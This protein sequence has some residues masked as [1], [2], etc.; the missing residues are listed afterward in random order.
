MDT[1][2]RTDSVVPGDLFYIYKG[3]D[4]M[5]QLASLEVVTE[6]IQENLTVPGEYVTQYSAPTATGQTVT[7]TAISEDARLIIIPGGAYAAMT[8]TLPLAATSVDHQRI[9]VTCTQ[10]IATLTVSGNGATVVNAPT[11]LAANA[12]F[13]FMYDAPFATWYRVG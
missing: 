6:A 8:I 5:R 2:T 12:F 7:M 3:Q 1:S 4:A 10:A 13:M 9:L 11:T